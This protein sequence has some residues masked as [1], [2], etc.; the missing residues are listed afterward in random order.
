V[1]DVFYFTKGM[2][3]PIYVGLHLLIWFLGPPESTPQRDLNWFS[4]F[5]QIIVVT[6]RHTHTHR[7]HYICSN[8]PQCGLI[9]RLTDFWFTEL[10]LCVENAVKP[11]NQPFTHTHTFN[12][13]FSGNTRVSRYQKGKPIWIL[14]KQETVSGSG[15]SWAICK[16]APH[17]RE[18][19]TPAPHHSV[20][21]R[22]DALPAAQPAASKH[23]R[24]STTTTTT[25]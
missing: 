4:C 13:P 16:S 18:I 7:P 9:V 17:S 25:V 2:M 19:T 23:C 1:S 11:T 14:L 8:R 24:H 20:F 15:I 6:S 3:L 10:S 22:P 12:G 5:T 21:Y